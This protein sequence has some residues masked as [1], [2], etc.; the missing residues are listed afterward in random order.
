[1]KNGLKIAISIAIAIMLGFAPGVAKKKTEPN[2]VVVQHILIAFKKSIKG[3]DIQ[4]SKKQAQALAEELY[5]R[6]Q[7]GEDFDAL[8][9]EYTDDKFPGVMRL[10]NKG[11]PSR[12][13]SHTRDQV[14][15]GFGDVSFELEVGQIGLVNYS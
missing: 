12:G 6:A 9:E 7:E 11:A 1:M 13:D 3:K 2:A 4:R 14:V 10:T 8:V 5:G 15:V